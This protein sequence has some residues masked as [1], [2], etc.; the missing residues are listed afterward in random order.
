MTDLDDL[1]PVQFDDR[2]ALLNELRV[3]TSSRKWWEDREKT[4]KRQ[5]LDGIDG[6]CA[7]IVNGVPAA[8]VRRQSTGLRVDTERL[9]NALPDVFADYARESTFLKIVYL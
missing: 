1:L 4:L 5:V 8:R 3:A 6:E 9:R 7:L 2:A